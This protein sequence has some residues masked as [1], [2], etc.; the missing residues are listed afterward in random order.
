M[1]SEMRGAWQVYQINRAVGRP[2]IE[3]V[4][5]ALKFIK[6]QYQ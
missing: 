1:K 6:E 2:V 4:T 5:D 3:S